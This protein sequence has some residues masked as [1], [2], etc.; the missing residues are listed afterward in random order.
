M[1][2]EPLELDWDNPHQ[3]LLT[4]EFKALLVGRPPDDSHPEPN[5]SLGLT[6]QF[7]HTCALTLPEGYDGGFWRNGDP[8]ID[9]IPSYSVTLATDSSLYVPVGFGEAHIPFDANEFATVSLRGYRLPSRYTAPLNSSAPDKY[10]LAS[11]GDDG[12]VIYVNRYESTDAEY[13]ELD[14]WAFRGIF[15]G[16]ANKDGT[17]IVIPVSICTSS[18]SRLPLS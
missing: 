2:E 1:I 8:V 14:P 4:T 6:A 15:N 7:S 11:L 12:A 9:L 5:Y 17:N 10:L 16:T 18:L 3:W 13:L